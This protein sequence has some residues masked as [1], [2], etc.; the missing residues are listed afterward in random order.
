VKS[1][2]RRQEDERLKLLPPELRT[3]NPADWYR[4]TDPPEDVEYPTC[5]EHGRY[6]CLLHERDFLP[7]TWT[8]DKRHSEMHGRWF[9][10]LEAW[11]WKH[12]LTVEDVLEVLQA[13]AGESVFGG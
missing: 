9:H 10:A 8:P 4:D 5:D 12:G 13:E 3:F 2:K 7:V 1:R 6:G 11:A